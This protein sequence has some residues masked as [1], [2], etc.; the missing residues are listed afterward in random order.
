MPDLVLV[1]AVGREGSDAMPATGRACPAAALRGLT[2]T[3]L[4]TLMGEFRKQFSL[5]KA[6][7][8]LTALFT[9]ARKWRLGCRNWQMNLSRSLAGVW[10]RRAGCGESGRVGPEPGL[11]QSAQA[12]SLAV[13]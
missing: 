2:L 9:W 8:V 7:M 3:A 6:Q 13:L 4:S 11:P 5:R 10:W 12:L 1:T